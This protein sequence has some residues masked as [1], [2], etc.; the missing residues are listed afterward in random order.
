LFSKLKVEIKGKNM[1]SILF[2]DPPKICKRLL[3]R[4]NL[5]LGSYETY[6]LVFEIVNEQ[7]CHNG[8]TICIQDVKIYK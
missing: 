1:P 6:D 4:R 5:A 3:K 7:M 2:K 8:F